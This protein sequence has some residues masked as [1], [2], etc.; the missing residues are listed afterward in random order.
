MLRGPRGQHEFWYANSTTSSHTEGS[1]SFGRGKSGA[2]VSGSG[3]LFGPGISS[4]FVD[5]VQCNLLCNCF[6]GQ[7]RACRGR[8]C[9]MSWVL[10]V[11]FRSSFLRSRQFTEQAVCP[12]LQLRLYNLCWV[13]PYNFPRHS[14][15]ELPSQ[16]DPRFLT[17]RN[18]TG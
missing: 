11:R 14:E 3:V 7:I 1:G 4:P 17:H 8:V 12:A 15:P 2:R 6:L 5:K 13:D 18:D 10:R 16:T 9:Q